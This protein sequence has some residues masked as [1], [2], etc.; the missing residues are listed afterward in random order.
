[1]RQK[2]ERREGYLREDFQAEGR[3]QANAPWE[4]VPGPSELRADQR[5]WEGR[6]EQRQAMRPGM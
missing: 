2:S 1:M 5:G 6:K 4:S 3:A